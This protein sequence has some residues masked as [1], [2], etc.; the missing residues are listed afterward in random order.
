[1]PNRPR[2]P[3]TTPGCTGT[4]PGGRCDRCL[5]R[6]ARGSS[7]AR[8]YGRTWRARRIPYL[9]AHPWCV[10][11]GRPATVPDHHPASRRQLEARG[12]ADP[13]ADEH[14]RALCDPCHRTQTAL[15]QPGGFNPGR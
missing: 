8:G 15:R 5:T 2:V 12:V 14:L 3:C 13:D 11:C 10:L 9:V 4:A 6:Q 1:M 7:A